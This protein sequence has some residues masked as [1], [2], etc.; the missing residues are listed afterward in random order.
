MNK[1]KLLAIAATIG[2]SSAAYGAFDA[3]KLPPL[4]ERLINLKPRF[5]ETVSAL[6]YKTASGKTLPKMVVYAKCGNTKGSLSPEQAALCSEMGLGTDPLKT[7][8]RAV[9][10]LSMALQPIKTDILGTEK[11]KEGIVVLLSDLAGLP[12]IKNQFAPIAKQIDVV[13]KFLKDLANVLP[14]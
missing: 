13:D 8:K 11:G 12:Q 2:A 10:D 9:L 1:S 4:V 14:G 3:T 5:E 7:W 6:T